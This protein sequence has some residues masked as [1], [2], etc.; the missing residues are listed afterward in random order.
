MAET[1]QIGAGPLPHRTRLTV[2]HHA[3]A[4]F[5]FLLPVERERSF[6]EQACDLLDVGAKAGRGRHITRMAQFEELVL[7]FFGQQG[8]LFKVTYGVVVKR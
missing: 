2:L 6:L 3:L 5:A 8:D 7:D 1:E 4:V